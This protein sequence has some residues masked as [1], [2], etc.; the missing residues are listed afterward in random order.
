MYQEFIPY[1]H[2]GNRTHNLGIKPK[3][4]RDIF[5]GPVFLA[6]PD[7]VTYY[8]NSCEWPPQGLGNF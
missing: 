1:A 5:L 4:D 7:Y 8:T 6:S 3:S 2:S